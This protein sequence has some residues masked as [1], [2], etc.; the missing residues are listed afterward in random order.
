MEKLLG[1]AAPAAVNNIVADY[2]NPLDE[3]QELIISWA[4]RILLDLKGY[5]RM[6]IEFGLYGHERALSALGLE[7]IIDKNSDGIS[8]KKFRKALKKYG[9]EYKHK[10]IVFEGPLTRNIDKL[11]KVID[12]GEVEKKL[13]AFGV[14]L[15]SSQDLS[16]IC[17]ILGDVSFHVAVTTLATILNI[18][19]AEIR[20]A[21]S[22]DGILNRTGLFHLGHD[23]S[24][25]LSCK[26]S[27][28]DEISD[29]LLE[30]S[31]RDI[32][33][34]LKRFFVQ[35][36]DSDL[37]PQDYQHID[38]DYQLIRAYLQKTLQQRKRGVNVLVYGAPGTGKTEL[39]RTIANDLGY[40]L[41]EV[42]TA[43]NNNGA[44]MDHGRLES[45]QLC[46]EVLKRKTNTLV[47]FDEIEDVFI[48]DG[49]ERFGIRTSTDSK[50]GWFNQLLEGNT[51]PSVWV[52]NV[53][54]HIDEAIIRRFDL[55]IE[56]KTPPREVRMK[57]IRKYTDELNISDQWIAKAS[58][59]ESLAPA[60]IARS[61]KV[62]KALEYEDQEQI[63]ATLEKV[64]SN[65]MGAMG[66]E[67]KLFKGHDFKTPISYRLDTLNPDYDLRALKTGL[68]KHAQGRFCFYGPSGTGKSEFARHLADTLDKVLI[69]KRASDLLDPYVGMTEKFL[70][71]MFE[72]AKDEDAVLLLDEADSFL[73]DR[74]AAHQSWEI[75][76]VNELLTQMEVFEG[77]FVCST[78]LMHNLDK[79]SLRRFD[80]KIKFDYMTREQAW[81]M[82]QQVMLDKSV[83]I[84][85]QVRWEKRVG[86]LK[87]LTPGDFATVVRQ[88]NYQ[89]EEW[90]PDLLFRGLEREL[91]FKDDASLK[92]IGF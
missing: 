26:I 72:Q 41:Y 46:Q 3:Y 43:D 47:M 9:E 90:S 1:S 63:E 62:I 31:D 12:L 80:L 21:V 5:T 23:D 60:L 49:S 40:Q 56:L 8:K 4:F 27:I 6:D 82:F 18:H 76:R 32:M 20:Q 13:L 70:K 54:S 7:K 52:S 24:Y 65:T 48:R 68:L 55:V 2:P 91:G 89:P 92:S 29:V 25:S 35:G 61:T 88:F 64:L 42:I 16:T 87:G 67:K 66:Y 78:N 83:A 81:A 19:P 77:I 33:D 84:E 39:V 15:H 79:A 53:I 14:L 71:A 75:S 30:T 34:S 22:L 86:S 85:D 11:G 17:D 44:V 57:I 73:Q 50:K 69:S 37:K 38:E 58:H 36:R 51:I 59:N 28:L 74:S 45:Y 10:H